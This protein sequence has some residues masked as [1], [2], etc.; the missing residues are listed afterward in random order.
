MS[1]TNK[2]KDGGP[3]FPCEHMVIDTLLGRHAMRKAL[4][5]GLS[6]RDYFA[7]KAMPEMMRLMAASRNYVGN[8]ETLADDQYDECADRS[9]RMADAM[10][11]ARE[12]K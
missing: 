12:P 2:I 10:L 5:S 9:Y 6:M 1:D 8:D 4:A 3:A 11:R 7:A